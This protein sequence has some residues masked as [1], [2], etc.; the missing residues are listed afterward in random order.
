MSHGMRGKVTLFDLLM[1]ESPHGQ[2]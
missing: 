1:S 2:E